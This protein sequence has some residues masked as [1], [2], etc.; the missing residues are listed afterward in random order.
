MGANHWDDTTRVRRATAVYRTLLYGYPAPF[1]DEYADQMCLMFAEQLDEARRAGA[2]LNEA[3]LWMQAARD[4]FTIA[5]REHWHVIRQDLRDA[6][7]AMALK[8]GF[9]AVAVL[10]LAFGIGANTAIFSVWYGVLYAP[11]P[12][13]DRPEDLTILTDPSA[14]GL[15]RGRDAGPRLWL[16][17]SEFDLL[18]EHA[19]SFSGVMASQSRLDTWQFSIGGGAPEE[20]RGRLVSGG[21]FDVLGVAPAIGRLFTTTEDHGEAA[22]AVISY[23]YWQRRFG[24]RP[25]VI[26]ETLVIRDTPISVIGVTAKGFVGETSGQQP[27]LWLPLRL[28]PRVLP[29]SNW[30]DEKP[31]DKVMWLHVFGRLKPGVTIAQAEAQANAIFQSG[32]DAFYGPSRRDE[33][34]GQRLELQR[35][36]RGASASRGEFSSSLTMILGAAGVLLLI[37]C[38]NLANLQLARGSARQT[39]IAIR[40][41]LGASRHRV[42]RQLVSETLALA[43]MGGIAAIAVAYAMHGALVLMLQEVEPRFFT[44]FA[45][46]TPVVAF[47]AAAA[48]TTGVMLGVFPA[49]HITRIDPGARLK[50]G[51]R[52][53]VGSPRELRAGRWLVGAQLALSVPLLVG[54]GLLGQTASNLQRPDLGFDPER[55]LLARVDLGSIVQDIPRR[56]RVLR[57]LQARIHRIPGVE[58]VG[59]SQLGLFAGGNSTAAI[60]LSGAGAAAGSSRESALDRVGANYFTTLRIPIL[61]GRDISERDGADTPRVCIVNEA[62]VNEYLNGRDPLGMRVTTVDEGARTTYEVV[63]LVRDARLQSVREN[64]GPRF[65]VPSEQRPASAVGRTFLIRTTAGANGVVP[66]IR[67]AVNAVDAGLSRSSVDI[68]RIEEHMSL[69]VADERTTARLAVVF[70]IVAVSLSALGLYGLLSHAIM[71]RTREIAMRIALG[72]QPSSIVGMLLRE[73]VSLV[74]TGLL[75]GGGLAYVAVRLIASRLYRV[76]PQD[77][78]TLIL[79]TGVLLLFAFLATY[80]PARRASRMDPVVALHQ[81]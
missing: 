34:L 71:R 16:S 61:R 52:N 46:T 66:A 37:A 24:G 3:V 38:G 81:G 74:A 39:E 29:G 15:L 70:G 79:A 13:V 78:F 11:L 53:A 80:V 7:R 6:F 5:P 57:E 56:D 14:S 54:A 63:G 77:P 2:W 43:V 1:R 26:G 23:A 59:F 60:E 73:T 22:F 21:F 51:S 10:S 33:A 69:L 4:L 36:A 68:V 28:Q 65:F 50:D 75:V 62:F 27:D 67:A 31:P 44:G 49:W 19:G 9:A 18:R 42:V 8:P 58:A 40:V 55:L 72:A 12:G 17:F 30:L 25:D 41:S 45:L 35:G 47:V 20:A 32:L 48:V 64:V 76:A